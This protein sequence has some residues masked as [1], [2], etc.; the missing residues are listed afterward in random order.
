[1]MMY[2]I[3]TLTFASVAV[4]PLGPYAVY[5][6][7]KYGP[8]NTNL[9]FR[10]L[11]RLAC[12]CFTITLPLTAL[13]LCIH[14][15]LHWLLSA[16][17]TLISIGVAFLLI[18]GTCELVAIHYWRKRQKIH[19]QYMEARRKEQLEEK[20]GDE[21]LREPRVRA[22]PYKPRTANPPHPDEKK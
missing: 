21:N 17:L 3:W 19:N 20:L 1:M 16:G 15:E 8:Y 13:L 14:K 12:W 9:I 4:F 5:R 6:L 7:W 11:G 18:G 2:A 10:L 22:K